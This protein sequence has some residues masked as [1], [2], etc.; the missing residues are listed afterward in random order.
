MPPM[1]KQ[2]PTRTYGRSQRELEPNYGHSSGLPSRVE[3]ARGA[4]VAGE[5]VNTRLDQD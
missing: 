2:S 3:L 1:L 4:V 5:A